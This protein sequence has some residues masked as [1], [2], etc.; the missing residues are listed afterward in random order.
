MQARYACVTAAS[1]QSGER[2]PPTGLGNTI[3]QMQVVTATAV[4]Q[5]LAIAL[6]KPKR[7]SILKQLS[8]LIN[9]QSAALPTLKCP[10]G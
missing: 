3:L 8:R 2:Q 9:Q 5:A 7:P 6:A 4:W 10:A 1:S